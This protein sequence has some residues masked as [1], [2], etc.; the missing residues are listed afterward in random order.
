VR[1]GAVDGLGQLGWFPEKSVPLL[2]QKLS[3]TNS[4]VRGAAAISLGKFGQEARSAETTLQ[5]LRNDPDPTNQQAAKW[6]LEQIRP[7]SENE[8]KPAST[9]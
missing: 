7:E 6:A 2:I 4:L 1:I 3:D 9:R 8:Q 5:Q